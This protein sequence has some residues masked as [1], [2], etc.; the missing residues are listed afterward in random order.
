MQVAAAQAHSDR[1]DA[2][3]PEDKLVVERHLKAEAQA[4][5]DDLKRGRNQQVPN[6]PTQLPK[7]QSMLL[8]TRQRP[9][10]C[11]FEDS[12]CTAP[13]WS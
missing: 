12:G 9:G 7:M 2:V 3:R 8:H 10:G 5:L 4:R 6:I 13:P 11:L 1:A